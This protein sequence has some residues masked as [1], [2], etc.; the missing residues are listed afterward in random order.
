MAGFRGRRHIAHRLVFGAGVVLGD[1]HQ[2]RGQDQADHCR[3]ID[4]HRSAG[5]AKRIVGNHPG[6]NRIEG[7]QS[8]HA[9][10]DQAAIERAHDLLARLGLH[11]GAADNRRDDRETAQNQ[12]IGCRGHRCVGEQECAQQHRGDQGHRIGLEKVGGHAGAV[13]DVV[14]NVVGNHR[15]VARV[16]LG[17]PG[18]DLAHQVGADVSTLGEDATAESGEDRDQ[19]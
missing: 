19:R 6:G 5:T 4:F 16:V 12:R 9:C 13:A 14:T 7:D 2:H 8:E 18:F 3:Q 17:N 10:D 11:E 15:R 1:D